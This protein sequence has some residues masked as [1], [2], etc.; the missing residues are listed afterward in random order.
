MHA[1]HVRAEAGAFTCPWCGDVEP[2]EMLLRS[3]HWV[4]QSEETGYDWCA[5]NL[6]C[7]GQD[8]VLNHLR[9]AIAH[10]FDADR[11]RDQLATSEARWEHAKTEHRADADALFVDA[12]ARLE[13]LTRASTPPEHHTL[14]ESEAVSLW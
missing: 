4:R 13:V 10:D 6:R 8:L 5:S 14:V 7:I 12:R 11:L 2:N 1:E 9:Y 3:N